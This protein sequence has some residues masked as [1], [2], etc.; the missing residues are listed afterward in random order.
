M[1]LVPGTRLGPYEIVAAIG[2]GG[3]GEVYRARDPRL[4]RDVAIKVLPAAFS[5]D[6]DRLARFEQEARA[7]A[8]L[9]HANILAVYDIGTHEG[10]PYIVSELLEGAS[11]RERLAA[12][13]LPARKAIEYAVQIAHGLA[14]AHEKGIVHR[15]LKPEN[16]FVTSDGRVKILD[17]GLAKLTQTEPSL[18]G[19]SVLPTTPPQT[20]P[21]TV[22]GTTGYMSP[23]QVRGREADPRSDIFAFGASLYEML[24]GRRAFGGETT[25]DAMSAILKEH[26]SDLP[27]AERHIPPALA[28]IVDRCLEKDPSS[29]F[30]ST[31]DLAFALEAMTS[32]S[33][34]RFVETALAGSRPSVPDRSRLIAWAVAGICA[35]A[36][37]TI[38]F[39]HFREARVTPPSVRF[40]ITPPGVSS[41]GMLALSP[42][43]RNLAFVTNNGGPYQLWVRAMNSL[44]TRALPGTDDAAY[45]FWSPD[46]TSLGFFAQGKLKKIAIAG[47]P[48]QTLC[49]ATNGRGGSWSRD[50]VIV[51]SPGPTSPILRVSASGGVATPVTQLRDNGSGAGHRFP[52]FLPDGNHFLYN[53]GSDMPEAAGL[54]LGS[55]DGASGVRILP[56]QTNGLYVPAFEPGTSGHLVYRREDTLMAQPFDLRTLRTAGDTFPVVE[57]VPNGGNVGFGA[58]AVSPNGTLV[59]GSGDIFSN[60]Q[61]VWMDRAGKRLDAVTKTLALVEA[62]AISPDQRTVAVQISTGSQTEIWLQDLQRNVI[63]RFTFGPGFNRRPVWAPEGKRVAFAYQGLTSYSG[64]IHLKGSSGGGQDELLLQG[65]VNAAPV[66][67]SSDLHWIAFEQQGQKTG[68]DLWLLPLEGNRKPIPYLQTSFDEASAKFAPGLGGPARWMAYQSNESGQNQVYV[69]SIP[70]GAKYQISTSGGAQPRWRADG[71][72]LYYLS[73]DQ[74]LMAVPIALG[75]SVEPG[76]PQPL[77]SNAGISGFAPSPDG[78]RFLVNVPAGG[79]VTVAPPITVVLNWTA[80]LQK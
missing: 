77:F 69:Q 39:V 13:A 64:E 50:G 44:E 23:E 40:Q 8:A 42:D 53:A 47:G 38:G 30:Q 37:A 31:R 65:G 2:A 80:T 35:V 6:P 27:L 73:T 46:G 19:A 74:K 78:Q 67:W 63:S 21:G 72:E 32:T 45:P 51:F 41:A 61:M 76:T 62:P 43:G 5:A 20:T 48:A 12:G 24:A 17:F 34:S 79:D 70:P 59:F 55:L 1:S 18:A 25:M 57:H 56:D 71:K 52:A 68:V 3:M 49:D 29:R 7:A 15:D 9:N 16:V 11:L 33:D 36:A 22:L 60:R 66:D 54:Y 58:F 4:G 75:A 10:A 28:R 14:A 26:P